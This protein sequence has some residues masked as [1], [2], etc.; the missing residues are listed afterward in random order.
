MPFV[1]LKVE[2]E[3]LRESP[4]LR[5][6]QLKGVSVKAKD[7]ELEEYLESRGRSRTLG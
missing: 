1:R 4:D 2:P 6:S 5:A 7:P 3:L